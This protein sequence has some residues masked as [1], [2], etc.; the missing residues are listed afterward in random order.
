MRYLRSNG[1]EINW[2]FIRAVMASVACLAIV[3]LQDVLGLDS[4]ARM[5]LPASR[6]GNWNWRF[7]E[8][9]LTKKMARRLSRLASLYGRLPDAMLCKDEE[10][11]G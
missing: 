2:D 4:S 11:R 3:P 8:G 9:A 5:N 1:E 10:V 6:E 7:R